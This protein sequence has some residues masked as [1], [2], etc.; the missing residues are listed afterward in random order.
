MRCCSGHCC[1]VAAPDAADDEHFHF[2]DKAA[3]KL[4]LIVGQFG[5]IVN[6]LPTAL[7]LFGSGEDVLG[8]RKRRGEFF[9]RKVGFVQRMITGQ[10]FR[11][12]FC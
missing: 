12:P 5:E 9:K 6:L 1:T 8:I 11:A 7:L 3:G 4:L 2:A 10:C